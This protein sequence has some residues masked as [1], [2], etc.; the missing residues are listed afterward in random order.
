MSE[1]ILDVLSSDL[2]R[3]II[4]IGAALTAFIIYMLNKRDKKRQAAI[5]LYLE[6]QEIEKNINLILKS[7]NN[8]KRYDIKILSTNSWNIYKNYF[9]LDFNK[10]EYD[11]LSNFYF[12][13]ESIENER[14]TLETLM[15]VEGEA[16]TKKLQETLVDLAK[17]MDKERYLVE[18]NR[19]LDIS[20]KET[21]S[22]LM[23]RPSNKYANYLSQFKEIT[24]TTVGNKIRKIAKAV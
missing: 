7:E 24:I 13:A 16:K 20:V 4:S 6:I 22:F 15:L 12:I 17:N 9:A 10:N 11:A 21:F 18:K 19:V 5:I 23:D 8:L 2:A 1:S 3:N 14:K